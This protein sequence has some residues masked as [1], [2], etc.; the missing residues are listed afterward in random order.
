MSFSGYITASTD[1]PSKSGLYF[2]D[3]AG[4]TVR[5]LDDLTKE[6]HNDSDDC[7]EYL[8]KTAQRNLRI[9]MQR[10]LA[11]RF[12][13]DKKLI[14][15][16][17]SEYLTD[18]VSGS[19]S[20]VKIRLSLPKYARIQILSIGVDAQSAGPLTVNFYKT[21]ETG[22]LL[23]TVTSTLTA[24]KN[25]LQLYEEFDGGDFSSIN[26]VLFIQ[27]SGVTLRQT[28]NR[29]YPSDDFI[30]IYSS[31]FNCFW[32]TG[33]VQ[34]V[35]SGGLNVKFIVYC[36][37]ERFIL[38]NLPLFQFALL[39]RIGVD[40]M[41]ERITTQRINKTSVLTEE[42]AK[43]LM[44]VFNEDYKA[45]LDSATMNI[46]MQEDPICFMCKNSVSAKTNLP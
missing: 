36:S 22:D 39:N 30:D 40:T 33:G 20:G 11:D 2:T 19:N 45:A 28:K 26:Q 32:G 35:N 44:T 17:T 5:L 15:R 23:G 29:F 9:D 12:H 13:I 38:E 31:N 6:D 1:T 25:T 42:R 37:M 4:C 18:Y 7:F 46:K 10:K 16:E 14:T 24:G 3:L 8:Y 41:K 43:E 21:D 27:Y 34:Q